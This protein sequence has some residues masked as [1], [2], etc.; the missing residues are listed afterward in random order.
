MPCVSLAVKRGGSQS[1]PAQQGLGSKQRPMR[2]AEALIRHLAPSEHARGI[3][4]A[5]TSVD[6]NGWLPKTGPRIMEGIKV[7]E[8]ATV[9]MSSIYMH[10]CFT[11]RGEP[12]GGGAS[13]L[14][15]DG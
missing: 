11:L 4:D 15:G 6:A 5:I 8:L 7:V 13:D 12:G 3:S 10:G 1:T 2:R 14:R 9:I